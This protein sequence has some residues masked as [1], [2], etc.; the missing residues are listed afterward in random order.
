MMRLL[1]LDAISTPFYL[2]KDTTRLL[3][4]VLN[5]TQFFLPSNRSPVLYVCLCFGGGIVCPY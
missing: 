2:R 3:F 1:L 5:V 4:T